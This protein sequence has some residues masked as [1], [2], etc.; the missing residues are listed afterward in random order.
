MLL[1]LKTNEGA[2]S[3]NSG[4]NDAPFVDRELLWSLNAFAHMLAFS[5]CQ[6][7]S[8]VVRKRSERTGLF[9]SVSLWDNLS[10]LILYYPRHLQLKLQAPSEKS[11]YRIFSWFFVCVHLWPKKLRLR[12]TGKPGMTVQYCFPLCPAGIPLGQSVVSAYFTHL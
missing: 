2:T 7:S 12:F 3:H 6:R 5:V 4:N 10:F 8:F 11:P 1:T 9:S